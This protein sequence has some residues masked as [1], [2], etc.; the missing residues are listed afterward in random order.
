M[1]TNTSLASAVAIGPREIIQGL[2]AF[3]VEIKDVFEKTDALTE[4]REAR[5]R[6]KDGV[7]PVAVVFITES[8]VAS[9]DEK[10]YQELLSNDLPVV[11][12]IP[13][14]TS[15]PSAGLEKLRALTKRA[16]GTDIFG[17]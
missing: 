1:S 2:A 3:G 5:T 8:L 9:F 13:D 10:E 15:T 17:S 6:T 16:V 7:T 14:L 4:L 11:L 12:T